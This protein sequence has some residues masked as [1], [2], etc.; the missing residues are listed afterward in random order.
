M[1]GEDW[2]LLVGMGGL[3]ILLG[4]VALIWGKREE[5]D[6]YD[7]SAGKDVRKYLQQEEQPSPESLKVGGW[8]AIAV[9]SVMAAM[10]GGFW[11][12]G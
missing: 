3:F 6:Y 11:L 5:R 7:L 2:L 1:P 8:I 4:L 12:W 10:G 9:G